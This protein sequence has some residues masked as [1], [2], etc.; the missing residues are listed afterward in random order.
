MNS[1][2]TETL[3]PTE[4][5]VIT[6][7]VVPDAPV[8]QLF[9]YQ[10]TDDDGRPLGGRQVIKY[11]D[12]AELPY[13]LAEQN[14]LLL[15]KLRQETRKNRL[16]ISEQDAISEDAPRY[17]Q[18]ISF[19]PRELTGDE[20]YQLSRDLI[21]PD[22]FDKAQ[23]TLFEAATGIAVNDL[24]E[25]LVSLQ[26]DNLAIKAE[27]EA[28]RF[29]AQNPAYVKCPENSEAITGWMS[30]YG[31]APVVENFQK[32]YDT[33]LS[34]GV[35][36]TSVEV[37]PQTSY[38]PPAPVAAPVTEPVNEPTREEIPVENQVVPPAPVEK[39]VVSRVPTGLSKNNSSDAGTPRPIGDDIVYEYIQ[40]DKDGRQVG[41]KRIFKGHAAI[42]A[43]PSEEYKRRLLHERGFADKVE[44]L[45]N[46]SQK[47]R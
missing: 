19:K 36:V 12:P 10:P 14:T 22:T 1:N 7:P 42:N 32:A 31:L 11:T 8:E 39:P 6:A 23:S 4:E 41:E 44:K 16:G 24:R 13:K 17:K 37:I 38:T 26:N 43:M 29:M 46:E 21:D 33:L 45:N 18:P 40:R 20:R 15:R 35:L 9:E 25:T 34:S 5:Q 2:E 30:R 27:R 47:R 3:V 28:D